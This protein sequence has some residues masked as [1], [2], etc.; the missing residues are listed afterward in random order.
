MNWRINEIR[1]FTQDFGGDDDQIIAR[2]N[3]LAGGTILHKFG[4]DEEIT[5]L[6]GIVVG[7]TDMDA[8]KVLRTTG[9]S[10]ELKSP[11]GVQGD[12]FVKHVSWKMIR[13]ICQTLRADLATDSPIYD[14]ELEL[15]I[16]E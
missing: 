5:K 10:Y 2:L 14:V 6:K 13:T 7:D 4:Y 3:P 1:I 12:Y 9:T 11:Y 8:I 15:Y 16:D